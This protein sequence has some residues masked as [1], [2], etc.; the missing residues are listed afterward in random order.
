MNQQDRRG[1]PAVKA[2]PVDLSGKPTINTAFQR[3]GLSCLAQLTANRDG[4]LYGEDSES[5]HQMRVAIRRLRSALNVF[6]TVVPKPLSATLAAKLGALGGCLGEAR[7]WDVFVADALPADDLAAGAFAELH[8]HA[9]ARRDQARAAARA[10]VNSAHYRALTAALRAWFGRAGWRGKMT[11]AQAA[12]LDRAVVPFARRQLDRRCRRL[13]RQGR[14][15]AALPPAER[16]AA[17]IAAK[18]LRYA[19]EFFLPLFPA[20]PARRY[21]KALAALQDVLGALNDCATARRLLAELPAAPGTRAAAAALAATD[22]RETRALARLDSLWR[23]FTRHRAFWRR[24][25]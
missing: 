20:K 22:A 24:T 19:T 15:L 6:A 7:D 10:M 13:R 25:A 3:I 16:H 9:L 11:A 1:L 17:R 12:A 14:H 4:V 18:K 21:V 2:A 5:V 23:R 8:Q